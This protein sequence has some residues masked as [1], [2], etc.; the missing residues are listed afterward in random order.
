MLTINA[1]PFGGGI[2]AGSP[3]HRSSFAYRPA[4]AETLGRVAHVESIC[5]RFGVPMDAAA[6]AF[7]T[8]SEHVDATA[9]GVSSL[10]RLSR[11][12]E[13]VATDAPSAL[14]DELEQ[15]PDTAGGGD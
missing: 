10:A 6:L 11:L 7:S 14:L 3:N 1:A 8:R 12:H 5:A 13:L 2:L 15:V 9:V 4:S